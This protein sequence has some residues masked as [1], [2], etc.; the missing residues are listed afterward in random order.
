MPAQAIILF[1]GVCNLCSGAVQF[2]I[3]RDPKHY[4]RFASLQSEAG[5]NL[6][7]QHGLSEGYVDSIVLLENGK[8]FTKSAAALRIAKK[9][10][11]LWPLMY[12]LVII[13]PFI[14][15]AMYNW[16]AARR[17]QWFGKKEACWIPD[18]ALR[19]LFIA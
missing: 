10:K 15:N 14:R 2:I 4:F 6:L 8:A 11:G 16:I 9:L 17:Y 5:N 13:P 1:D 12:G 3:K 18:T 7:Q 19:K